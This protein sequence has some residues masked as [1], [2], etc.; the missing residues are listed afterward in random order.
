MS[1]KCKTCDSSLKLGDFAYNQNTC[2]KC[3]E[4]QVAYIISRLTNS[5]D[6]QIVTHLLDSTRILHGIRRNKN[7]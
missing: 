1:Y 6:K 2:W 4:E 5:Y 7:D 3:F